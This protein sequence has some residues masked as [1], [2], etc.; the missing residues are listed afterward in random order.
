MNQAEWQTLAVERLQ[1][2]AAL[3]AGGRWAFA[4]YVAGYAVECALKSCVLARLVVTGWVFSDKANA[5]DCLTHDFKKLVEVAGLR[6]ELDARLAT[7]VPFRTR[8]NTAVGWTV[9]SRYVPRTRAEAE[10]LYEA[11]GHDPDGVLKWIQTYW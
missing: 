8:W 2:A 7:N 6:P 3:M 9:D 4:Y 1:D 5:K 11:I 10:V